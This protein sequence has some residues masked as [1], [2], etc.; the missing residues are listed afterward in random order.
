VHIRFALKACC[1]SVHA[2]P[3]QPLALQPVRVYAALMRP[4]LIPLLVAVISIVA[5]IVVVLPPH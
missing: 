1:L 3:A 4:L 2:I 5:A